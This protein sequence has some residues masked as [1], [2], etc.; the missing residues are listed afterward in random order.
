LPHGELC[1]EIVRD[2]VEAASVH[3][4]G[5][6]AFRG[7][8]VANIRAVHELRFAGEVNVVR[9]HLGACGHER[10]AVECVGSNGR[11][12]HAGTLG[13]PAQTRRIGAVGHQ[14]GHVGPDPVA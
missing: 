6:G 7:G 10:L 3:Q 11:S 1:S 2:R 12:Y 14:D 5:T 8:V 9:A 13:H 4:P